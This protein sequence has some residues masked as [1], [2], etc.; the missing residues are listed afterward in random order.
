MTASVISLLL[1]KP[2]STLD[3]GPARSWP[4][5][6]LLPCCVPS[7]SCAGTRSSRMAITSSRRL[8]ESTAEKST[9]G[10]LASDREEHPYER[11]QKMWLTC[12]FLLSTATQRMAVAHSCSGGLSRWT[13]TEHALPSSTVTA[14]RRTSAASEQRSSEGGPPAGVEIDKTEQ[15]GGVSWPST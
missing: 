14:S 6:V 10:S 8:I 13:K 15:L 2:K 3:L 11:V 1:R 7:N 4:G 5:K 12:F 9:L